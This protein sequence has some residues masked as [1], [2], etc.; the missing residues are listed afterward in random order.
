MANIKRAKHPY[1]NFDKMYSYNAMINIVAGGRGI[2]K[3]YGAVKSAIKAYLK[4]GEQFI[5]LRRYKS[6]TVAAK[7]SFFSAVG[8]EFPSHDLR[9]N[10]NDM[11]IAGIETRDDKKREWQVIG[12]FVT[13]SV[14]QNQKSVPYPNV[15]K[16]IFDEFIMNI[17]SNVRYLTNEVHSFMEFFSTVDRYQDKTIAI[18]LSNAVT[19][20]NPYFAEWDIRPDAANKEWLK[21]RGGM[22]VAN[23]PD[24]DD[25][26]HSVYQTRL[27]QFIQGTEYA[28]YAVENTFKDNNKSLVER[29]DPNAMYLFSIE[30]TNGKFSVWTNFEEDKWYCQERLPKNEI[31][32]TL[33]PHMMGED[34][35]LVKYNDKRMQRLVS[36][37]SNGDMYFDTPRTRNAFSSLAK[38]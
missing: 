20:M 7:G 2:G 13:L 11:E 33:V 38:R 31:I 26:K 14:A 30:T 35:Q 5:Y 24:S 25:F 28:E 6:E 18:L 27:G 21:T 3:T 32:L 4:T 8:D 36:A 16:V 1:Y 10:G 17:G 37:F 9:V 12:Y 15:T 34:K 23:F 19:I 29:K 22:I